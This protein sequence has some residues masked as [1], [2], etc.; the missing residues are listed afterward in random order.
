M[1]TQR[2]PVTE[3]DFD[4]IKAGLVEYL[5]GQEQFKDYNF[6]GSNMSVLLDVLSYNTF[7]NNFYNNMA[8]SEMFLDSAQLRNSVVS[9][10]KELNYLPRSRSS[11]RAVVDITLNTFGNP[12]F[13]VIPAKTKFTAVCGNETYVFYTP[14]SV[15]VF[16]TNGQ[17]IYRALDIYEGEYVTEVFDPAL[18]PSKRY[19]ISNS[20]VDI[21]SVKVKITEN[22]FTEEYIYSQD[23]YNLD[24]TSKV[25]FVQPYL[26]DKY[27]I[28][29]GRDMFGV[30]PKQG[31]QISIEYR[32][33]SGEKANGITSFEING[34]I[35]GFQANVALRIPSRGGA[36]REDLNSIKYFA[37]KSI[38][39]QERAVVNKDYEILLKRQFPEIRTAAVYGGETLSP[40]QYGRVVVSVALQDFSNISTTTKERY[41]KFLKERTA[42]TIEPI[43]VSS[44]FAYFDVK[45]TVTYNRVNTSKSVSDIQSTV[46]DAILK[47]SNENLGDFKKTLRLSKLEAT[48]DNSD[49]NILS[50]ETNVSLVIEI[51]PVPTVAE[52]FTIDYG[53]RL[54]IQRNPT[55]LSS[56]IQPS[57]NAI[58]SSAFTYRGKN[59]YLRDDGQGII[60]IITNAG[61]DITYVRRN[62]GTVD[63]ARG[64]VEI[65]SLD[66][67]G[68]VGNAIK[69][70]ANTFSND[71][72]TP[73]ERTSFVREQDVSVS[74][75]GVSE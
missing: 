21:S 65:N 35:N 36:E 74:V 14:E 63:Y 42:L 38:Q 72:L 71:I 48:I 58:V 26:D 19:L 49:L 57:D 20:A 17:Y 50:N 62:V 55:I 6:E 56:S 16:P 12:P 4:Q 40:P 51:Q 29:F 47:F 1:T 13:V 31:S 3:L 33:A 68:Y 60:N 9:H 69:I 15:T 27:E 41:R 18:V 34:N 37:P 61:Q 43:I 22:D 11:A 2:F 23:L 70:Y 46:R 25:F 30:E 32:L 52:N 75:I 45:T 54:F 7:Q 5:K 44:E 39:V 67:D 73:R 10:A 24:P 28:F 66:V 59:S 53:N 64:L 8:I